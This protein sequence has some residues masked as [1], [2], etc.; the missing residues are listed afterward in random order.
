MKRLIKANF[1][2]YIDEN[3]F[4]SIINSINE[5][6]SI[7]CVHSNL[8]VCT[9]KIKTL[10]GFNDL[11]INAFKQNGYDVI[12]NSSREFEIPCEDE[13]YGGGIQYHTGINKDDDW[14]FEQGDKC[15]YIEY[16]YY[17]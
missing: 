11:I 5:I 17:E 4:E 14:V 6:F 15:Y 16:Y 13:Q 3:I 2:G 1:N 7:E 8:M 12:S 9:T 10:R